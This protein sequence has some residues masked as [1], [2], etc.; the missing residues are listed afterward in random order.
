[1]IVKRNTNETLL[2]FP[3]DFPIKVMGL[4]TK[5]FEEAVFEICK[6]HYSELT[7]DMTSFR[8][9]ADGKYL[10]ITVNIHA[11]SKSQLDNIYLDLTSSKHV[12]MAL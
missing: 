4:A 2:K 1:M 9:S 5:E 11:T 7:E 8:K 12:L 3:C 10:S 6:K